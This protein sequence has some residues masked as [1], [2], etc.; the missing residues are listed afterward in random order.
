MKHSGELVQA[1]LNSAVSTV[2]RTKIQMIP[3]VPDIYLLYVHGI[4]TSAA[5]IS[6]N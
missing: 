5:L 3:G 2:A 1:C 6:R 4:N